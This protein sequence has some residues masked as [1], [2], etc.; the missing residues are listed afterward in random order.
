M[1]NLRVMK[2]GGTSVGDAERIRATA[3]IVAEQTRQ[4]PTVTVVS[5]M[6]KV[7][8]QLVKIARLAADG[9]AAGLEE[10]LVALRARHFQAAEALLGP[11][12]RQE[13]A[14]AAAAILAELEK[15]CE[16][17]ARLG[18]CPAR[19][20]DAVLGVGE[21]LSALLLAATLN[22]AGTPARALD[23]TRLVVTDANFGEAEPQ[24]PNL[25]PNARVLPAV[26]YQEAAELSYYGA[27][28]LHP[29]TLAP[30]AERGIPVWTKSSFRPEAPGTV[31]APRGTHGLDGG[32]SGARAVTALKKAVLITVES[33]GQLSAMRIMSRAFSALD[34]EGIDLLML[35]QASC[36]ESFCF[37]VQAG[38][39]ERVLR[40]LQ[41]S[42]AVELA[43]GYI[44]PLSLQDGVAILALIGS[45]MRG[46]VGIAGKLF[47]A[48]WAARVNVIAI[49]QGATE[50]N[51]SVAVEESALAAAVRAVHKA[52]LEHATGTA[53]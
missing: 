44:R 21:R 4:Q 24:I 38:D 40:R 23:A 12:Q 19:T 30:L 15:T 11:G 53:G 26:T 9:E 43:H 1:R 17:I 35:S 39:A 45:G 42:F 31:I 32:G 25:I 3:A 29:K 13:Y 22:Q 36:E 6:S 41:E 50:T 49:A 46:A 20:M 33:T 34:H 28:V 2:F 16:G 48:L 37:A 7:T 8:D 52:L 51:I 10:T 27:K 47:G 18:H 5:A 14:G